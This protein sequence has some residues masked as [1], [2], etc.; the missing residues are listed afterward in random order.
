MRKAIVPVV[1]TLALAVSMAISMTASAASF[2]Y[3]GSLQ[4]NGKPADGK[5]DLQLT[6]Y[7][8]AQGGKVVGGPLT[9]YAVPVQHGSFDTQAD[10]GPL[11]NVQ[12]AWLAVSVKTA[13]SD[14]F[15]ALGARAPVSA[16][17]TAATG[18]VCP[19]AWT[20]AGN[21]GNP[22]G[23]YLGTADAN[24]LVFEVNGSKIGT[25]A[26]SPV[27]TVPD[28]PN[29]VFG[30]STNIAA[31]VAGATIAGG[32]RPVAYCGSGG[33]SDC[34]NTVGFFG[35]GSYGTV[36][37]G[38]GN[39]ADGYASVVPGG[40]DNIAFGD[41]SFAGGVGSYAYGNGSF[42]W[43]DASA[44]NAFGFNS[45]F[46]K[47][48]SFNVRAT[49]GFYL[50]SGNNVGVQLLAGSGTWAPLSDRNVKTAIKNID[51]SSILDGVVA[52][53]VTSWQ[54][55]TQKADIRHLGPMAQDFYA[56][57]HLGAD[58]RHIPEI[59]EGGVALAAIQGLNKKVE[60]ENAALKTENATLKS[61]IDAIRKRLDKIDGSK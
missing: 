16:D 6:L 33:Q 44:D 14:T 54:Y 57:F 32:G 51:V 50:E 34:A 12:N 49:G 53:P 17:A 27:S 23:S 47:D 10:F 39:A 42:V 4:D 24:P 55:I 15:S 46:N 38:R 45:P 3:H 20:L 41:H 35:R 9:L 58:N 7:S 8:A 28:A 56:A 31:G 22:A 26:P 13:G 18:S 30:G 59:D 29:V 19:G 48:N 43:S 61:E 36:S 5:Y 11:S 37:G 2:S 60:G 21:A 40:A 1:S 52:M 25:L